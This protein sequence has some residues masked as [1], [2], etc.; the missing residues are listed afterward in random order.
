M[1]W[2]S[3]GSD[4]GPFFL[5]ALSIP[6]FLFPE[7]RKDQRPSKV[8]EDTAPPNR[9]AP[10]LPRFQRPIPSKSGPAASDMSEALWPDPRPY[11]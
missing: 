6:S 10:T 9:Q 11:R 7:N 2:G 4:C 3:S 8:W 5:P 1:S